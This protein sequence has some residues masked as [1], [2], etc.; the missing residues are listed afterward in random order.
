MLTQVES[1]LAAQIQ[2]KYHPQVLQDSHQAGSS[3]P[4]M[5]TPPYLSPYDPNIDSIT[6]Q[7]SDSLGLA[8]QRG[9]T[10]AGMKGVG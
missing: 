5:F 6:V 2:N 10:A 1:H 4:R 9:M 7:Q 3:A 8:M